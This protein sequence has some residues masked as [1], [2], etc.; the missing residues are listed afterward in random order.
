MHAVTSGFTRQALS[1]Q[2]MKLFPSS[3]CPFVHASFASICQSA[4]AGI[5]LAGWS[6][7]AATAIQAASEA[8]GDVAFVL[9]DSSY[10]SLRD[11]ADVQAESLFGTWARA[12]V[13]GAL[14]VSAIR[15]GWDGTRPAPAS[16]IED[17]RS[18]VLLIH[19]RRD[20]FTP[21]EHSEKIYANSDHTRTRLVIPTWDAP[22]AHSFT[23]SPLD[24][25]AVVDTF[26]DELAPGFGVRLER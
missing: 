21:V 4:C 8:G 5:G 18:P 22:H 15:S 19:S 20:G 24:Y 6:Y 3:F 2:S 23:E 7:G 17:V 10:S 11:I 9:A 25:T 26:L 12:F 14:V 1:L 16:A 13:P